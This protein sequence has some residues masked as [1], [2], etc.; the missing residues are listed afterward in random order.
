M[1]NEFVLYNKDKAFS[2]VLA[3]LM[4]PFVWLTLWGGFNVGYTV[5]TVL[6]LALFSI[7]LFNKNIKF[8]IFPY[9]CLLLA[10]MSS[11]VFTF[12]SDSIVRFFLFML[13]SLAA[14]IWL[15]YLGGYDITDDYSLVSAVPIGIFGSAFGSIGKSVKAVFFTERQNKKGVGKVVLGAVCAIPTIIILVLLLRSSDAAFDGLMTKIGDYVGGSNSIIFKIIVSILL[16]PI[17]PIM[18][19]AALSILIHIF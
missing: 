3:L 18:N 2:L 8:K 13:L 14:F 6:F 4:V 5:S 10:S 1:D 19:K 17:L 16:F 7:Y 11:V 9:L 12:S 15:V